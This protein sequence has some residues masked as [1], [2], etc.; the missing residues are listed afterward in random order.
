MHQVRFYLVVALEAVQRVVVPPSR[1]LNWG[2]LIEAVAI[3]RHMNVI[4]K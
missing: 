3:Q 4:M 2:G 1:R